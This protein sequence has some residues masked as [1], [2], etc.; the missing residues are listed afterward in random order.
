MKHLRDIKIFR[1]LIFTLSISLYPSYALADCSYE[2]FTIS[3][4][5][6]T[7]INSFIDQI[8]DECNYSIIVTDNDAEKILDKTMNKTNIKNMTI[9]EVFDFVL[10][11]NNLAYTL[12]NNILKISYLQTKTY[13]IDYILSERKGVGSTDVTLSSS[14]GTS[15][16]G[17]TGA[18]GTSTQSNNGKSESGIKIETSDEVKFWEIL[19]NELQEILNRPEDNYDAQK[20]IINKNAGLI[21]VTATSKQIKRL[22][23]YIKIMQEKVHYQVLIDV[24]MLGVVFRDSKSTGIDWAQLYALQNLEVNIDRLNHK[25]VSEF[26]TDGTITEG[27]LNTAFSTSSLVK[28]NGGGSLNEVVKFLKTQGDVYA[29]SNPKVLTLNNQPALIT[30]GTEY[31]YKIQQSTNQQGSGGGLAAT[32]QNDEVN[33]V[34]AGVLLDITP[35]ISSDDTIT[36]KINPSVSE[37]REVMT[38]GDSENRTMPPDLKR[39]QLASVVTVKDGNR[40]ILGG[41]I[42]SQVTNKANKVP[43]LG[44]IPG[45]SYFFSYEEKV[46]QVEELVIIIEPH[47]IR[48]ENN[49]ISLKDLGYEGIG[50]DMV[51][52]PAKTDKVTDAK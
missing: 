30:V 17:A 16:T 23:E 29:I 44:D 3:S 41:L 33:S 43:L 35:E 22:D 15:D 2:L 28:I 47:I 18:T 5:K 10:K 31:F 37:T 6:G 50:N 4:A 52:I 45:I 11:E 19:D 36:L 14:T 9:H 46:K 39:R 48:K 25:N 13:H 21:T 38:E 32:T 26:D 34:F 8:T 20:P 27:A 51:N 40:I 1:S 12:K 24:H 7:T 49:N 42:N